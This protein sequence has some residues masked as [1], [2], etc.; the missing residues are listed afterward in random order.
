MSYEGPSKLDLN[1][2]SLKIKIENESE[3]LSI[4][5]CELV[6]TLTRSLRF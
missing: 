2:Y 4:D 5:R 3:S 1:C 6:G